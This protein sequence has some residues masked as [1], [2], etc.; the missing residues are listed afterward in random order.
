[1]LKIKKIYNDNINKIQHSYNKKNLNSIKKYDNLFNNLKYK[2]LE[3]CTWQE[4]F[5]LTMAR[6]NLTISNIVPLFSN[7]HGKYPDYDKW[8]KELLKK[9]KNFFKHDN[10]AM[11]ILNLIDYK[12]NNA[13][14]TEKNQI[15]VLNQVFDIIKK[16]SKP[17]KFDNIWFSV[18]IKYMNVNDS[19]IK[20]NLSNV[21]IELKKKKNIDIILF[22]KEKGFKIDFDMKTRINNYY[23]KR[24]KSIEKIEVLY[25][26][27]QLL[28]DDYIK[29]NINIDILNKIRNVFLKLIRK[30][31]HGVDAAH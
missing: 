21:F 31:E 27:I 1:M 2:R 30:S 14:I 29:D 25:V 18:L 6:I 23:I 5:L 22:L 17:F 11:L 10:N 28:E 15:I 3:F 16:E 8:N 12:I 19:Y 9:L 7:N 26:L 24:I 4:S 13:E 20:K